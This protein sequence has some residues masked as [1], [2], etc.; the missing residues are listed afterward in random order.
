[1]KKTA[2]IIEDIPEHAFIT[3]HFVQKA[4]FMTTTCHDP[5]RAIT[6]VKTNQINVVITDLYMPEM[7]GLDLIKYIRQINKTIPI[8]VLSAYCCDE[9]RAIAI[10]T[11]ANH[12]ICKPIDSELLNYILININ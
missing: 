9:N 6:L 3:A 8:V 10:Q 4:G 12:F 7:S 2:L 11:G 1:M 5:F